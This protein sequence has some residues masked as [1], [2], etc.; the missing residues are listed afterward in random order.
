MGT[1]S[2][3]LGKRG[4][5]LWSADVHRRGRVK[6]SYSKS[7]HC[8]AVEPGRLPL[9]LLLQDPGGGVRPSEGCQPGLGLREGWRFQHW[10]WAE[11]N[12]RELGGEREI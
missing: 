3:L 2:E 12:G 6:L 10:R 4:W 9:V 7:H 11:L 5:Q 1:C 8:T